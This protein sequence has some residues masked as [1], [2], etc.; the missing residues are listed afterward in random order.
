MPS[1]LELEDS[2]CKTARTPAVRTLEA[3]L[4]FE[5]TD[6][7]MGHRRYGSISE[8]CATGADLRRLK[9]EFDL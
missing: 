7:Q 1:L 2:W 8:R 4:A 3:F 6:K 5:I 9:E